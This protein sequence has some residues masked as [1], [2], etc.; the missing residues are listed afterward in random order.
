LE[1]V[2]VVSLE[3]GLLASD[4]EGS[5]EYSRENGQP[6]EIAVNYAAMIAASRGAAGGRELRNLLC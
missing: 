3:H 6:D 4:E 5:Q 1:Y 2:L